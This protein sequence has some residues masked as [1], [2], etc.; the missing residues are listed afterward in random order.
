MRSAQPWSRTTGRQNGSDARCRTGLRPPASC[1]GAPARPSPDP[2]C[3]HAGAWSH[4]RGEGPDLPRGPRILRAE[5]GDS[6]GGG[7]PGPPKSPS[8]F[9]LT[10]RAP[11][12]DS[13]GVIDP[14]GANGNREAPMPDRTGSI[15]L[16]MGELRIGLSRVRPRTQHLLDLCMSAGI[17][18]AVKVRASCV[19]CGNPT[20]GEFSVS[21]HQHVF[22]V[23]PTDDRGFGCCSVSGGSSIR[24]VD[25]SELG[26]VP[27]G[28][29]VLRTIRCTARDLHPLLHPVDTDSRRHRCDSGHGRWA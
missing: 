2:I 17:G 27:G 22:V 16:V 24:R 9:T 18:A 20:R 10:P 6:E 28:R 8:S 1:G 29:V 19:T 7:N 12:R 13:G 5:E 4:R 26:P 21:R 11:F 23:N 14:Y 3:R 25:V 15:P